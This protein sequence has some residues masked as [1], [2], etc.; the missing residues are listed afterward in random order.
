M[1]AKRWICCQLGAR[2]HYAVPRALARSNSLDRLITD[3]WI[4][5]DSFF[6]R[7]P[8]PAAKQVRTRFH[9]DLIGLPIT[10]FAI[11]LASFELRARA[12]KLS[13][14]E[15]TIAR[16]NW[17]QTK[18][19]DWLRRRRQSF[20]T[21][22][23]IIL[24]SY[25][26]A[27]RDI[28]RLAK[29][30]GWKTVLGQIDPGPVEEGIVQAEQDAHPEF[31][32]DWRP[33]PPKYWQNWREECELADIIIV[34]SEWSRQALER[35]GAD[36][37][38]A[39]IVPLAYEAQ[40]TRLP[41]QRFCPD[42]F[43]A[44]R[45]LRVLFL[46]QINLRKGIARLLRAAEMLQNEPVEFWMVGPVQSRPPERLR[47]L[48]N[49]RWFGRVAH[50]DA[51]NYYRRADLFILPTLSDGFALTQL[52]AQAHGLPVIASR[53]CGEV[54]R[55]GINGILLDEPTPPAIANA[56]Q[57]CLTNPDRLASFSS[58]SCVDDRF[59]IAALGKNLLSIGSAL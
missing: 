18:V 45:P 47:E 28:F 23:D 16:N 26:Y 58:V 3:N 25:S 27:A 57:F 39:L 29:Q 24:F 19:A 4:F 17:F 10:A 34:N 15:K 20:L 21:D 2:E 46:G 37:K 41:L 11:S 38:K 9:Q 49:V 56:M 48:N 33:A 40:A 54:V 1:P 22:G 55:D 59:S 35:A 8:F 5:P 51:Q 6:G 30:Q 36:Q 13:G 44:E 52:E 43:T 42:R 53:R 12:R 14:W 50:A 7:L 32:S 31:G